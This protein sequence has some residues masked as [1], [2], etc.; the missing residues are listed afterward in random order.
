[1]SVGAFSRSSENGNADE[2]AARI[3]NRFESRVIFRR[4]R[5]ALAVFVRKV[6]LFTPCLIPPFSIRMVVDIPL[7]PLVLLGLRLHLFQAH[8]IEKQIKSWIP[9]IYAHVRP[10]LR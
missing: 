9:T 4:R 5:H 2:D 8:P 1:M 6:S 3:I 10:Q 7:I